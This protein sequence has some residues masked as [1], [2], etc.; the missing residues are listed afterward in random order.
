MFGTG[1][2]DF[3]QALSAGA[4]LSDA[5]L[6]A[7]QLKSDESR[8]LVSTGDHFEF[9]GDALRE[10]VKLNAIQVPLRNILWARL[11]YL[12]VVGVIMLG[13]WT[14]MAWKIVPAFDKIFADFDAELP[15]LTTA[16]ISIS[17]WMVNYGFIFAFPLGILLLVVVVRLLLQYMGWASFRIPFLERFGF[18]LQRAVILQCL[19]IVTRHGKSLSEALCWLA[20]IYPQKYVRYRL[21]KTAAAVESGA[22][23]HEAM[24]RYRLLKRTD[25]ALLDAAARVGNLSWALRETADAALRRYYHR[26]QAIVQAL[27]LAILLVLGFFGCLFVAGMFL[28]LVKLMQNLS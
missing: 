7:G 1:I 13:I 24:H 21:Q 18:P 9:P 14:F 12:F 26:T 22:A 11:F 25:A 19:A 3:G 20:E 2:Q 10:A 16:V 15:T 23:W 17:E 4:P 6:E 5:L 27:A 28:P 8:V